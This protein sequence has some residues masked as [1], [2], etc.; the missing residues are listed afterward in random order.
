MPIDPTTARKL[1][2]RLATEQSQSR[3]PSVAAG[4]VRDGELVW[5][6]AVGTLSGRADGEPSSTDTQYR[7][8][9][10]TKTFVGGGGHAAA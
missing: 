9:S 3:L 6:G 7:M 2:L 8:G 5:S 10:I 4:L 1:D